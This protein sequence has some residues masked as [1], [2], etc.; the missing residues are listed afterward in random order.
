MPFCNENG[1]SVAATAATAA[2]ACQRQRDDVGHELELVVGEAR[3]ETRGEYECVR[4]S[5]LGV[6]DERVVTTLS[7][8]VTSK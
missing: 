5:V 3:A 2:A 4:R 7:I 1:K 8:R 6:E